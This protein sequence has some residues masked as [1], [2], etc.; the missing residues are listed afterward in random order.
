MG[1]SFTPTEHCQ[2]SADRSSG[3]FLIQTAFEATQNAPVHKQK[4]RSSELTESSSLP[5]IHWQHQSTTDTS[6]CP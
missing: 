3:H 5:R 4:Q 6:P 1:S 2:S